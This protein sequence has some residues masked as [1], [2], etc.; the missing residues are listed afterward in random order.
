[1]SAR[2]EA[3]YSDAPRDR[4]VNVTCRTMDGKVETFTVKPAADEELPSLRI[5]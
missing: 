2:I 3:R 4:A 5:G 1:V